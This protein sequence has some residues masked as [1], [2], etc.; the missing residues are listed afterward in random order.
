MLF[1]STPEEDAFLN[2]EMEFYRAEAISVPD[3]VVRNETTKNLVAVPRPMPPRP[4]RRVDVMPAVPTAN[5][6]YCGPSEPRNAVVSLG[7]WPAAC[8]PARAPTLPLSVRCQLKGAVSLGQG[9]PGAVLEALLNTRL[10]WST[11]GPAPTSAP[12]RLVGAKA[13][14]QLEEQIGY[15]L[16]A[17]AAIT[18]AEAAC[19]A[20]SLLS[21]RSSHGRTVLHAALQQG[22]QGFDFKSR[23]MVQLGSLLHVHAAGLDT[24]LE[25]VQSLCAWLAA[26]HSK[27]SRTG[28]SS[29]VLDRVRLLKRVL[30][31]S[32][33]QLLADASS[34]WSATLALQP[35]GLGVLLITTPGLDG[36]CVVAISSKAHETTT[37]QLAVGDIVTHVNGIKL[38]VHN[39]K[40]VLSALRTGWSL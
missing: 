20:S 29:T 18:S 30:P 36:F 12:E 34:L 33:W 23:I 37:N 28:T 40:A 22:G 26:Q 1:P 3:Q 27:L 13:Q 32:E 16:G 39:S 10:Q 24:E 6:I 17:P 9:P 11:G 8:R 35:G 2:S 14:L 38:S 19:A 21:Q 25:V 31:A 5:A 15:T 4:S 7:D